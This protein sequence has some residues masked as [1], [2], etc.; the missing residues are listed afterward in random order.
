MN[1]KPLPTGRIFGSLVCN[2]IG[3]M[4]C[5]TSACK[6]LT[7]KLELNEIRAAWWA[8]NGSTITCKLRIHGDDRIYEFNAPYNG[9]SDFGKES[10]AQLA[11]NWLTTN[12]EYVK[13]QLEQ[14]LQQID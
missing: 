10:S 9:N 7:K 11:L 5:N 1:F 8:I 13:E 3:S 2:E 12:A 4:R 14:L 6:I